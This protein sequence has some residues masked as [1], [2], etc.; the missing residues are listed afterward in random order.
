M[1]DDTTPRTLTPEHAAALRP[2]VVTIDG[3]LIGRALLSPEHWNGWACPYFDRPT[4]DALV[5]QVDAL[6]RRFGPADTDQMRFD[7]DRLVM[8]RDGEEGAD[9]DDGILIDGRVHYSVGAWGWTWYECEPVRMWV[10]GEGPAWPVLY[11]DDEGHGLRR[12]YVPREW[13]EAHPEEVAGFSTDDGDEI[14]AAN[15]DPVEVAPGIVRL[16]GRFLTSE[17]GGEPRPV[18]CRQCGQEIHRDERGDWATDDG[19]EGCTFLAGLGR[20]GHLQAL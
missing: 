13:I 16:L 12:A 1:T 19:A 2:G 18:T 10:D 20:F 14:D 3:F 11:F 4:T 17:E 5:R 8:W 9:V 6:V 15:L 7:G